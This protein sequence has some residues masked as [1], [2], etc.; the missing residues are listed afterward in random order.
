M[1]LDNFCHQADQYLA[2]ISATQE[3]LGYICHLLRTGENLH[4]DPYKYAVDLVPA[5]EESIE[6]F[7]LLLETSAELPEVVIPLR[8]LLATAL[9]DVEEQLNDLELVA[10]EFRTMG[11]SRSKRIPKR[12]IQYRLRR[13]IKGCN[14]VREEYNNLAKELISRIQITDRLYAIK[15]V[16]Y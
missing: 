3:S 16:S 2:V 1:S 4:S 9:Y 5:L 8:Y 10:T 14:D 7:C 15:S 12:D 11:Y 6:K 13:L